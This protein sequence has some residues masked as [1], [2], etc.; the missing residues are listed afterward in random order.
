MVSDKLGAIQFKS[1][2]SF[3]HDKGALR[4][5]LQTT[6]SRVIGRWMRAIAVPVRPIQIFWQAL[7]R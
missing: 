2:A 6:F 5:I 7:Q 1:S 4:I 3:L